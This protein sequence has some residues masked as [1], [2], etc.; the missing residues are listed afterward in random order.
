MQTILSNVAQFLELNENEQEAFKNILKFRQIKKKEHLLTEG[1][2]CNFGVYIKKGCIRH[3]Y[4]NDGEESTGN[5]FFEEDWF[6]NFE[7]FLNGNPSRLN[8]IAMEDCELYFIYKN[9]FDQLVTQYPVFNSLLQVMMER[10]ISCL[11]DKGMAMSLLSPEERYIQLIK[12]APKVVERISLKH[13]AS[14]LGVKPES[15]SRIRTRV[16]LSSKS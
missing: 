11:T 3:Y 2:F 10:A 15:L 16:T 7:S 13:I 4:L 8:V 1:E 14:F 6:T 12:D 9:D 5:F